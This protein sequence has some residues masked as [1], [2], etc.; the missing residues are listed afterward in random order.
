MTGVLMRKGRDIKNV[1]AQ[2][3]KR[4]GYVR[5]QKRAICKPKDTGSGEINPASTLILDFQPLTV[6]KINSYC[7]S[8]VV[9]GIFL[10]QPWKTNT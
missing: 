6:K 7:L 1:Q 10:W 9:C 8:Y 3:G 2:G 4:K 5:T